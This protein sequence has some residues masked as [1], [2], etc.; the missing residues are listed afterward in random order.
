MWPMQ[1]EHF[2]VQAIRRIHLNA[3]QTNTRTHTHTFLPYIKLQ[4]Y[5]RQAGPNTNC[6]PVKQYAISTHDQTE[7]RGIGGT[8][9]H[10]SWRQ[11]IFS[12]NRFFD[13]NM[14]S[15]VTLVLFL[16]KTVSLCHQCLDQTRVTISVETN[17]WCPA[18]R[19]H[20]SALKGPFKHFESSK[21]ALL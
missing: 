16:I 19:R 11:S 18:I 10:N 21:P 12:A 17:K 7:K 13:S 9:S 5:I 4:Y 14:P 3:C 8:Y 15:A 6:S 20:S 2:A 1:V